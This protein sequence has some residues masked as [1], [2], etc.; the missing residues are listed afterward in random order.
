M[1]AR[2]LHLT[3][4]TIH[5][6]DGMLFHLSHKHDLNSHITASGPIIVRMEEIKPRNTTIQFGIRS[7]FFICSSHNRYNQ[8]D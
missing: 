8:G 1:G 7:S 4:I 3:D 5:L 2:S 6:R